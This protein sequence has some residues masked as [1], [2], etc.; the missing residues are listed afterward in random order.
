[1]SGQ[2]ADYSAAQIMAGISGALRAGDM[3]AVAALM[4][5]LAVKDPA[6]AQMILDALDLLPPADDAAAAGASEGGGR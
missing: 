1:M 4:P 6:S 2:A 5:M 3:H